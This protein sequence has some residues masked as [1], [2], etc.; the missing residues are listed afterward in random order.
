MKRLINEIRNNQDIFWRELRNA[1]IL[2]VLFGVVA[3][4]VFALWGNV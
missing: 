4:G 1:L 2:S 3:L